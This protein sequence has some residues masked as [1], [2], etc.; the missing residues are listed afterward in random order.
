MPD[1]EVLQ[2][3]ESLFDAWGR[4]DAF[5]MASLYG[6]KG[7]LIRFDGSV[8]VGPAAIEEHLRSMFGK[9]PKPRLVFKVREIRPLGTEVVLLRAVAGMI[10]D[11]RSDILPEANANHTLIAAR[12]PQGPWMIE[13]FQ[14]TP[15]I[16]DGRPEEREKLTEE[17]SAIAAS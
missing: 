1:D 16:F 12:T 2:L 7:V 15:A 3:Y 10:P 9:R 13:L 4:Q 8:I 6:P 17:L 11:G 5:G 14:N